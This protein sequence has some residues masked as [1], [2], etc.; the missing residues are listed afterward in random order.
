VI[1]VLI[2]AHT[3]GTVLTRGWCNSLIEG[4]E[5]NNR[6]PDNMPGAKS[7]RW[8]KTFRADNRQKE[9]IL[10][11]AGSIVSVQKSSSSVHARKRNVRPQTR[12]HLQPKRV[13]QLDFSYNRTI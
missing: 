1:S 11:S 10:Q 4:H 7:G 12:A 5:E 3:P 6:V 2:D 8:R 13:T 9:K